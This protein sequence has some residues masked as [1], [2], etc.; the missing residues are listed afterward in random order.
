MKNRRGRRVLSYVLLA[1][2]MCSSSASCSRKRP[3]LFGGLELSRMRQITYYLA[4]YYRAHGEYPPDLAAAGVWGELAIDPL[5]DEPFLYVTASDAS[6]KRYACLVASAGR[7]RKFQV[8]PEH[9][10][11]PNVGRFPWNWIPPVP[12]ARDQG[13]VWDY[14]DSR[15]GDLCFQLVY[16]EYLLDERGIYPIP[17]LDEGERYGLE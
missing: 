3:V 15:G 10:R 6:G 7:D 9:F 11:P 14:T 1:G 12:V 4:K 5:R 13:G 2:A 17:L 8:R 16:G